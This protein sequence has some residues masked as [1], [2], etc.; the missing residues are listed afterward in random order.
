MPVDG[1]RSAQVPGGANRLADWFGLNRSSAV[2]LLVIGCLG[3][4]EEVWSHF[5][6]LH[7]NDRVTAARGGDAVA[8]TVFYIGLLGFAKNLLE[9]V[10]YIVGGRLAHRLGPRMALAWSVAPMVAGFVIMLTV[11]G[12]WAVVVGALL[13]TNWEPLSVP[14]TFDVVGRDV[15]RDRQTIAFALQSIQKRVP[16]IIGPV[17]G[18]LVFA[19]AGFWLNLTLA[20]LLVAAAVVLQLALTRQWTARP[21]PAPVSLAQIRA[22][23]TP[24]LRQLLTAEVFIR[25][26]DWFARDFAVLYVVLLLTTTLGWTQTEAAASAGTLVA[27]TGMTALATY[28]PMAKWIDRSAS[29]RPFIAATF[30]FFA[31]FPLALVV[32]PK[33]AMATGVPV[34]AALAAAFCLNG[35]RELGEPAR[36]AMIANGFPPEIRAQGIG[37]YWGLRSFAFCPAPLVSAWLWSQAGPD[38]TFLIGSAIGFA[39]TAWFALRAPG[40]YTRDRHDDV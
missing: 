33:A 39:G 9:G 40:P 1:D 36:K 28:I 5:V 16:K 25:W 4:S 8:V 2:L 10:G 38:V 15:R 14:A 20:L 17:I 11:S 37:W 24:A 23:S 12:P 32:L 3:L 21:D 22:A 35:L 30:F 27:L 31:L 18:G 29:P 13:I 6:A 34:M 7:L 26:G 19:L